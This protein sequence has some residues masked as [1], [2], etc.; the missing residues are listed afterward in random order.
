MKI[1]NSASGSYPGKDAAKY[2]SFDKPNEELAKDLSGHF[3]EASVLGKAHA[4]SRKYGK[5]FQIDTA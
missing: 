2:L 3:N 5:N 4:S 1:F